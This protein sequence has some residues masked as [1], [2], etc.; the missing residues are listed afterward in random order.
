MN[1]DDGTASLR[2]EINRLSASVPMAQ[3]QKWGAMR[4]ND[5]KKECRE[6]RLLAVKARA[7]AQQL[8]A[9]LSILKQFW[10]AA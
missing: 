3:F 7:T 6:A 1:K 9:K 2:Q 4:A 5:Y 8:A 10:S